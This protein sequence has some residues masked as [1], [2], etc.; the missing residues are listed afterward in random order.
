M[1]KEIDGIQSL[2]I[3]GRMHPCRNTHASPRH[4]SGLAP[5]ELTLALPIMLMLLALM[6]VFGT[7]G[8]WK[9][10]TLANSRQAIFRSMW[11]RTTDD[12]PKPGNWW[13]AS[14]TMSYS[15]EFE[16]PFTQDP[17]A[18]H[19]VV[20]GPNVGDTMGGSSL[21]V[22]IDTLDMTDGMH[23]GRATIDHEPAMW[24]ALSRRNHFDREFAMFAGHQWQHGNMGISNWTRRVTVT[25][26]YE[27]SKYNP[28]AL[29][30]TYA[31]RDA[32]LSNPDRGDL[33][34][35]DRDEELRA[36]FGHFVDFHPG[37]G[38]YCT[39]DLTT[40][41]TVILPNLQDRI[42]G[43]QPG[44]KSNSVPANMA[45]TFLSMYRDQL[46]ALEA[47]DP[48]PPNFAQLK[49]ELETKIR[50]LEEFLATLQ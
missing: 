42:R 17:F 32:I 18:E 49:A 43:Q 38:N 6:V 41:Q 34:V 40:M 45:R 8:A 3:R 33:A 30:Q 16:S 50:Q 35:L 28:G 24:P 21:A 25:Y 48:P 37:P 46:D 20:R 39:H 22:L 19:T 47:M 9:V 5:L 26:D 7:A 44:S 1:L 13:P 10:R 2:G 15:E 12:D 29:Q 23:S 4:R 11:P 31:A 14:A 27:L 36:W